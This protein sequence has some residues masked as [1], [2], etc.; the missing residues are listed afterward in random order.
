[1]LDKQR[2]ISGFPLAA[3]RPERIVVSSNHG[4]DA[5]RAS[6]GVLTIAWRQRWVVLSCLAIAIA[7]SFVYL[8]HAT[9]IYSSSAVVYI[10]QSVPKAIN[11]QL[12][13]ED[14]VPGGYLST[15]C[16][17]ITSTANLSSAVQLPAVARARV[18]QGANDPVAFLKGAVT[19]QPGKQANLATVTME[20]TDPQDAADIVNGVVESYI[21]YQSNQHRSTA[22]EVL[23]IL[24]K[25]MDRHEAELEKAER[26]LED[27][28]KANPEI[29]F[30]NGKGGG[31]MDRLS[32]VRNELAIAQQCVDQLE[33]LTS[34]ITN[35]VSDPTAMGHI[36]NQFQLSTMQGLLDPKLVEEYETTRQ[37]LGDLTDIL[38]AHNPKV[39]AC[40][41]RLKRLGADIYNNLVDGLNVERRRVVELEEEEARESR[42]AADSNL[43]G[44]EY[45]QMNEEV[46]RIE[47][48]LDLL[49]S[50]MKEV[51]VTENVGSL[52]VSVLEAATPDP[53][54]VRPRRSQALAEGAI[55][56][57]ILGLCLG[58]LREMLD[59]RIRSLDEI[60]AL[61]SLPE[62]GMVPRISSRASAAKRG[63][64]VQLRP[65]SDAA[66]AFRTL[67][68][69]I[70]FGFLT[71]EDAK[72]ILITSPAAGDG[73]T[74]LASNL[75]IA[76]A[77]SK[78]RVL[79]IDADWRRPELH[80]TFD[81]SNEVGVTSVLCGNASFREAIQ[82]TK[83]ADL[84]LLPCG[85][86]PLNPADLLNS[87]AFISLLELVSREYDQILID[88][89]PVVPFADARIL[90]A[91]CD[92]TILV[93]RANKSMRRTA[94]RAREALHSVNA[95]ILGYVVNDVTSGHMSRP[96]R[97]SN[98]Y[99]VAVYER[100]RAIAR[101][102]LG[103]NGNRAGNGAGNGN[104]HAVTET[105]IVAAHSASEGS[106]E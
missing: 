1:M 20:S 27:F 3:H 13:E 88:S 25:E 84:D 69:A 15:Q 50:R 26:A 60:A 64:E 62:L 67:R 76:V 100:N 10:Q 34:Q 12:V 29:T 41:E 22:V 95:D 9:P 8:K 5:A 86:I 103:S 102:A 93:L 74:F 21:D 2:F 46:R 33:Y 70:H 54:P 63:L 79:L 44:V 104:S 4:Q 81:V 23:N 106:E 48:E 99:N 39:L 36:F 51:N 71:R 38:G 53:I 78:R 89:P 92:A 73:K 35:N 24:Q 43:K 96:S 65:R 14:N 42:V 75:A 6:V 52:T 17:V 47:A 49:D 31:V 57:L 19:A 37:S 90:A 87:E 94:E 11:D 56:G 45:D 91:S 72:S 58:L 68:T 7:A 16:Q 55:G 98:F 82:P 40:T 101:R 105:A 77:Q 83:I 59:Q 66:E 61:L 32:Q 28:R 30:T 18:L 80:R 97:V 85:P